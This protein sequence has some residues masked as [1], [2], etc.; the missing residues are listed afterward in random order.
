MVVT[1][2]VLLNIGKEFSS[3]F[4]YTF[5]KFF[6][7]LYLSRAILCVTNHILLDVQNLI[8]KKLKFLPPPNY[9]AAYINSCLHRFWYCLSV[10]SS[11]VK[12]PEENTL[13]KIY[14]LTLRENPEERKPHLTY[15]GIL[16]PCKKKK[17]LLT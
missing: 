16:K 17:I 3:F 10:P 14:K 11:R 9:Y 4:I 1:Y 7:I 5:L 6:N 2:F 15:G 8:R 12:Q 13:V